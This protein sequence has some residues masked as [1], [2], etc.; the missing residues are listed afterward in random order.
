[1]ETIEL[2]VRRSRPS[3]GRRVMSGTM[4]R[5]RG[6]RL[7]TGAITL[8]LLASCSTTGGDAETTTPATAA[9]ETTTPPTTV[10]V[11]DTSEASVVESTTTEP[12]ETTT[13]D[14]GPPADLFLG[15]DL[16]SGDIN[17]TRNK[18]GVG[19]QNTN[20]L[21]EDYYVALIDS[22]NAA[23]GI[24]GHQIV[25]VTYQP[26]TGDVP[27][28]VVNQERCVAYF[29]GSTA[30]EVLVGTND[31]ILNTCAD[32]AG[33][34]LFGRGF[35]GLDQAS[36]DTYTGFVNPQA[37]TFDSAARATVDLAVREGVVASGTSVGVIYP[38]CD[39]RVAVF[40]NAL[41]PALERA[42]A[43]LST[44]EGTCARSDADQGTAIAE[45]P[46]AILQWKSDD[47]TVIFNLATGFIPV[48]LMMGEADKQGFTPTWVLS[49]N[50]E[51]GA[52]SSMNPPAEQMA[53]TIAAGWA[54]SLDTFELDPSKL[55]PKAQECLDKYAAVGFPAPGNL[56]ELASQLDVCSTFLALEI[57]LEGT[58]GQ[59][60]RD[61]MLAA[62]SVSTE[63]TAALTNS[64]DWT[65]SRQPNVTYQKAVFDAATARFVYEGDPIAMPTS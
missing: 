30:A 1:M 47:V 6:R 32:D 17:A 59:I 41:Q 60:D 62:L 46:N 34:I 18:Y 27:S 43:T 38:G 5:S 35:T 14:P 57:M 40:E 9:A 33:A 16:S 29:D 12:A 11:T 51:F 23:G 53:N 10:A 26:P 54:A 21:N 63:D 44:F 31:P 61:Q 25:P 56:G 20:L 50:N 28:D 22:Y 7:A 48:V 64:I 36:L 4:M 24:A 55:G 52:M 42:G 49:T 45:L 8:G 19:G 13:T 2:S 3:V 39:D 58:P 15:F 65:A 37:A